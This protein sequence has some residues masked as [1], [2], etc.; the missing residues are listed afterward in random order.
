[1]IY[2]I[3]KLLYHNSGVIIIL[4]KIKKPSGFSLLSAVLCG[5]LWRE[6]GP[7]Y[8]FV[9]AALLA[10]ANMAV[11]KYCEK[12]ENIFCEKDCNLDEKDL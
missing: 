2:D 4:W 10:I 1:V 6:F 12:K 8:V 7:H 11:A 3:I 5:W 9:F